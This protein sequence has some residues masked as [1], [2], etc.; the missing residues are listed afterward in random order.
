[1]GYPAEVNIQFIGKRI[2]GFRPEFE[3]NCVGMDVAVQ[4]VI[5]RT[6]VGTILVHRREGQVCY[7][8]KRSPVLNFRGPVELGA[9]TFW[10]LVVA[11]TGIEPVF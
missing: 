7:N 1:M 8:K 9:R 2:R 5:H 6:F 11:L 3:R 10:M 4:K